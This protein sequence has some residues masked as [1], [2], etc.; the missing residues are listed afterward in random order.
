MNKIEEK[1]I[2]IANKPL[3]RV[4]SEVASALIGKGEVDYSPNKLIDYNVVVTGV[5]K[6]KISQAKLSKRLYYR[7]S[8]YPGALKKE[9]LADRA[10]K[11]MEKLFFET[12]KGMLPDNRLRKPRLKKLFFK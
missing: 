2:D 10:D 7:H 3:G 6:I 12:V 9:T 4:A 8:G 1:I 11:S 5:E